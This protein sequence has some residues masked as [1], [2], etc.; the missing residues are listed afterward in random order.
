MC[1]LKC[2]SRAQVIKSCVSEYW[3]C[4]TRIYYPFVN[5]NSN[6]RISTTADVSAHYINCDI[7]IFAVII[8]V[9][10]IITCTLIRGCFVKIF[11]PGIPIPQRAENYTQISIIIAWRVSI[12]VIKLSLPPSSGPLSRL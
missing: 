12:G 9:R 10:I 6:K 2:A 5:R 4:L 8:L 7:N 3:L 11:V 1:L